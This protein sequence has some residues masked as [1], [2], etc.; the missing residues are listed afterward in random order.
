MAPRTPTTVR[1]VRGEMRLTMPASRK[2]REGGVA[3]SPPECVTAS[4]LP[5]CKSACTRLSTKII[6]RTA[7]S[8]ARAKS[9]RSGDCVKLSTGLPLMRSST[10]AC[11]ETHGHTGRGKRTVCTSAKLRASSS[12]LDASW[13]RSSCVRMAMENSS[14][15]PTGSSKAA[16]GASARMR[17]ARRRMA[18][19][20]SI[21]ALTPGWRTFTATSRSELPSTPRIVARY[22][23]AMQPL[24]MG[25][26]SASTMVSAHWGPKACSSAHKVA[27]RSSG[28]TRSVIS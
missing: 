24:P 13:R 2:A 3:S 4:M 17:A 23:C 16:P 1:K 12:K 8:P 26:S 20:S 27:A 5:G 19:S 10:S 11:R 25:A 9:L 28:R 15:M 14:A 7:S 21:S 6:L 22:T 18:R